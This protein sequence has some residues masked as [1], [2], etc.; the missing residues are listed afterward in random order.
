MFKKIKFVLLILFFACSLTLLSSCDVS[1][2]IGSITGDSNKEITVIFI[3]D[4][5]TGENYDS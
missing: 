1:S 4:N 2:I 5:E 3:V